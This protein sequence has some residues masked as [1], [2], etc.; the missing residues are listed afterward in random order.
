MAAETV[1]LP[2]GFDVPEGWTPLAP[3]EAGAP[4][5]VFVAV[6]REAGAGFT[7]NIT[8][9]VRQR[10]DPAPLSD[11]AE[12]AVE[13]L[14][15]TMALVEVAGRHEL[16]AADAPGLTQVLRLRTGEGQELVQ[17][18]VHLTVPG[19][20]G[21]VDRVVLELVFTAAPEAARRLTPDFRQF[22]A[23]VRLRRKNPA[24]EGE[25]W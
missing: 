19:P 25:P 21:P 8:L 4:G 14:G 1:S 15:R 24:G 10:P 6:H 22:V 17:T 7:P 12:E 9:G 2:L 5:V 13:R 11:I 18:Q 23:S 20:D 16:G 3:A